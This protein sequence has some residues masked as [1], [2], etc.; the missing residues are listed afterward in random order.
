VKVL[1]V[2]PTLAHDTERLNES[3]ESLRTHSGHHPFDILVVNNSGR[4]HIDG[5][6]PVDYVVSPG[7]NLGY[8]GALEL[9]RRTHHSDFLWSVQD[10]MTLQNGVLDILLS[11]MEKC[12][13][14]AVCS[15]VLVRNGLV[16]ARSRAGVFTNAE[17]T[18]WENHP[19]VDTK[20]EDFPSDVDYSFVSGSGALFRN[21]A[22]DEIG[23]FNLDLYPL[24]HVDVDVCARFLSSRWQIALAPEAHISHEIQGS[25]PRVLGVTLDKRNRPIVE[26]LL[27][28]G[29]TESAG[30]FDPVDADIVFAVARRASF[31]FLEVSS[32]A[33]TQLKDAGF[34]VD[35]LQSRVNEA[36]SRLREVKR[37]TSW[38]FTAPIRGLGRILRLRR[39]R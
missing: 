1:A 13:H 35:A 7:I 8:V 29:Q 18:R 36:E 9:A 30:L 34:L 19:V 17:R 31:L 37:S 27:A 4:S 3:I 10:D 14:L 22:L 28:S 32:E 23:G 16:P 20:L 2:I 5:L 26:Q 15:P 24:M 11:E 39:K 33:N 12:P 21:T 38:K 25:T 6:A